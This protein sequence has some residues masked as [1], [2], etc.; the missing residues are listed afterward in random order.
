MQEKQEPSKHIQ[1]HTYT[2]PLQ[3]ACGTGWEEP[4]NKMAAVSSF[5]EFET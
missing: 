2:L 4:S 5:Q 3:C 1:K